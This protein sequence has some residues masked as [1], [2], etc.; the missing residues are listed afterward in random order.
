[1]Q[2]S[3]WAYAAPLWAAAGQTQT[4]SLFGSRA[5]GTPCF[6]PP[7]GRASPGCHGA[8]EGHP[9]ASGPPGLPVL[10][11]RPYRGH[12]HTGRVGVMRCPARF[13]GACISWLPGH[14]PACFLSG[15]GCVTLLGSVPERV[16]WITPGQRSEPRRLCMEPGPKAVRRGAC[17]Q[18]PWPPS[19]G[20]HERSSELSLLG[21]FRNLPSPRGSLPRGTA[22]SATGCRLAPQPGS[23]AGQGVL[24]RAA[25][26]QSP[27][28]TSR[29]KQPFSPLL[30]PQSTFLLVEIV[31][32]SERSCTEGQEKRVRNA[33]AKLM[34]PFPGA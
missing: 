23:V 8:T 12:Q 14:L 21:V 24:A 15:G 11:F 9:E 25:A 33:G 31:L 13:F 3:P 20:R 2:G 26:G 6:S 28:Q 5:L 10:A 1:M 34:C 17:K 19:T 29:R 4:S 22:G 16:F 7:S 18:R 32:S 27:A 30:K